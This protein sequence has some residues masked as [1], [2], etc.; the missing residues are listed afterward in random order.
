MTLESVLNWLLGLLQIVL[1][2]LLKV[3]LELIFT[4]RSFSQLTL[5]IKDSPFVF[6]QVQLSLRSNDIFQNCTKPS[7]TPNITFSNEP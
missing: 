2:C 5:L 3:S 7:G 4:L 6:T 1:I